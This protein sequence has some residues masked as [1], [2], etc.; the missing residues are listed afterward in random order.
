MST[1]ILFEKLIQC[2][3][4]IVLGFACGKLGLIDDAANRKL[5][6]VLLNI[7]SPCIILT[8]Y[9]LELSQ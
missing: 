4:L 8:S 9:Q 2:A 3:L 6:G 1:S 5:S 7:V